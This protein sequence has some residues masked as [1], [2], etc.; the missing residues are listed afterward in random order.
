M[1]NFLYIAYEKI[2]LL[3][4]VIFRGGLPYERELTLDG[5]T[6]FPDFAIED[7]ESGE[8]F[9]WEHC[10]MLHVPSYKQRWEEKRGQQQG[11]FQS[12]AS[13]DAWKLACKSS[14]YS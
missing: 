9:Y 12:A 14:A 2:L 4:P 3:N 1:Q 11:L 13:T 8:I 7:A 10:G 5:V 6:R